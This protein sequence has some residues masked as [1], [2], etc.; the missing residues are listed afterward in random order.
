MSSNKSGTEAS[1]F[2]SWGGPDVGFGDTASCNG[3]RRVTLLRGNA[4]ADWSVSSA[5]GVDY[6]RARMTPMP[7]PSTWAML[8]LLLLP[9]LGLGLTGAASRRPPARR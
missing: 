2:S 4:V 3:L 7:E 9:L 8:L 5:C 1:T 6:I